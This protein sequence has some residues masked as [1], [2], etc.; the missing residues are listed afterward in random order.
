MK[1]R[2]IFLFYL[3]RHGETDFS[4]NGK[5]IFQGRGKDFLP[6]SPKGIQQIKNICKD[7][8]LINADLIL[9]S[10]YT[11]TMQ[12]SAII[13]HKLN[14][15]I[16]VEPTLY[17]WVNDIAYSDITEYEGE[18]RLKEYNDLNGIYP[19]GTTLPWENNEM[20]KQ[21]IYKVLNKYRAF[22]N[23]IVVCHGILIHSLFPDRWAENAEIIEF[24][25][26]DYNG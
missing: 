10:P 8:R 7:K 13:S 21:R 12:S 16:C 3:I 24:S 22:K 25:L 4:Y 5:L 6:L 2:G 19:E 20:M 17:E 1:E 9:S 15:K 11:R 23:V 26:E 14:I 18:R